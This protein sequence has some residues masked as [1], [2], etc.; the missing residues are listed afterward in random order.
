MVPAI[1]IPT[2]V[3]VVLWILAIASTLFLLYAFFRFILAPVLHTMQDRNAPPPKEGFTYEI[4]ID[5][6]ERRKQV[7]VGQ[8]DGHIA[9]R[10]VGI[11]EDHLHLAFH[12]ERDLEEYQIAVEP[13]GPVFFRAPHHKHLEY[14]RGKETFESRELI[15]HPAGFRI[16]AMVRDGR[17]IQYV[18]FELSTRFVMNRMGEEK[19]KFILELKRI[20]PG[21]DSK[22]RNK[23]GVFSFSRLKVEEEKASAS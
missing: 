18:E 22:T 13:G 16:A 8:L 10:L 4:L 5:Q 12:K 9:T 11:K 14:M 1:V 6:K 15:G 7:S 21:L 3:D 19:M 2:A 23:K 20:F 17:P